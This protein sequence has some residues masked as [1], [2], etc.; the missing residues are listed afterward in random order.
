MPTTLVSKPIKKSDLAAIA[1]ERFGN[2][3]KAVVDIEQGLMIIGSSMHA[4]A[5]ALLLEQGSQ[6]QNLWGINIYPQ[7]PPTD[8]IEF[9]SVINLRPWQGNDTRG[10]DDPAIQEKIKQIV[11]QLVEV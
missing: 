3:V 11:N 8:W 5:E 7:K 6:Q 4:D 1:K 9:D 10:V 2:L